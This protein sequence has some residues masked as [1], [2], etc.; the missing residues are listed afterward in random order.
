VHGLT[1]LDL[2]SGKLAGSEKPAGRS[3]NPGVEADTP[4][5]RI[6]ME[7]RG[8]NETPRQQGKSQTAEA[9][10]EAAISA[11][12]IA[13]AAANARPGATAEIQPV[14]DSAPLITEAETLADD[15]GDE[16]LWAAAFGQDDEFE[17][18]Q[19]LEEELQADGAAADEEASDWAATPTGTPAGGPGPEV[20][21]PP[22]ESAAIPPET[23][24]LP[25]HRQGSAVPVA[26]APH[27]HPM[28]PSGVAIQPLS[29]TAP[30]A[31]VE[32][33][34][35]ERYDPTKA[36]AA[37]TQPANAVTLPPHQGTQPAEK[38]VLPKPAAGMIVTQTDAPAAAPTQ[39]VQRVDNIPVLDAPGQPMPLPRAQPRPQVLTPGGSTGVAAAIPAG[40]Q[41]AAATQSLQM[42]RPSSHAA[43]AALIEVPTARSTPADSDIDREQRPTF[44]MP[45]HRP[46]TPGQ[47]HG[48]SQGQG[49]SNEKPPRPPVTLLETGAKP[50]G[51]ASP[52]PEPTDPQPPLTSA[53]FADREAPTQS[54][55]RTSQTAAVSSQPAAAPFGEEARRFGIAPAE[56]RPT[57]ERMP[58]PERPN[59]TIAANQGSGAARLLSA[60]PSGTPSAIP[61]ATTLPPGPPAAVEFAKSAAKT[62]ASADGPERMAGTT[63]GGEP[64]PAHQEVRVLAGEPR[65]QAATPQTP[66]SLRDVPLRVARAI[67]EGT[68]RLTLT[69]RPHELGRLNIHMHFANGQLA[70]DV[71]ADRP[72]TLHLL[73]READG[74]ERGLRQAGLELR[75]GGLQF[76]A[77][78][79]PGRERAG[80]AST[81][82][83]MV[84]SGET[85]KDEDDPH[86]A[87]HLQ[88]P[89]QPSLVAARSASGALDI[90]L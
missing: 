29:A 77:Q 68:A 83:G 70:V 57:P 43:P 49:P 22:S 25:P 42:S 34:I 26:D 51:I 11:T 64:R 60:L 10:G 84:R 41:V 39:H 21:T 13:K 44:A 5:S 6:L 81:W 87:S 54:V 48:H 79:D 37:V 20:A 31:M 71:T 40:D 2:L 9:T 58:E 7:L 18:L 1:L 59:D 16:S 8:G 89:A 88:R 15:F 82:N 17:P 67:G 78:G 27:D 86:A 47:D 38:A 30:V 23:T 56:P 33:E 50:S 75:E 53:E 63:G 24:S 80:S 55:T 90:R 85:E 73:Q 19:E 65:P 35:V 3:G 52:R 32:S 62:I 14:A 12:G 46:A 45:M 36:K 28:P 61:A 66:A 74:F 69:L 72:E 76:G 4:F